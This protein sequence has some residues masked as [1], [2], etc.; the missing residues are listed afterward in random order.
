MKKW[1]QKILKKDKEK[2]IAVIELKGMIAT[3]NRHLNLAGM[4]PILSKVEKMGKKLDGLVLIINS[5]GGSPAQSSL[6][7]SR[8]RYIAEK[9]ELPTY[10]FVEDVAAS[11]GYWLACA[12]DEIYGDLNSIIG[13]IGVI[14]S[15]FGFVELIEKIGVERRVYTS[16]ENKSQMD[17][18]KPENEE[19]IKRIK[20]I[21]SEIHEGFIN[22][23]KSRRGD[24]ITTDI[25]IFTGEFWTTNKAIKLGLIDGEAHA[26]PWLKERFGDKV[27]LKTFEKPQP[28]LKKLLGKS[29]GA[30]D[31]PEAFVQALHAQKINSRFGL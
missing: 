13:S 3:G 12:A 4:L 22:W 9:F 23:V 26:Y 21:Q 17:P 11:G 15:G 27:S 14:S 31:L 18:F 10:A 29:Q 8:I 25:N 24:K 7:A 30:E 20:E 16:G 19:D 1:I 28:L 6:I 2:N 5:P